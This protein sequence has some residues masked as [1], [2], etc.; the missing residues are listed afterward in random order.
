MR[1]VVL[2]TVEIEV[3]NLA[4]INDETIVDAAVVVAQE[5]QDLDVR[6]WSSSVMEKAD[7]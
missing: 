3:D 6:E 1:A 5:S 2:M 7:G 4:E